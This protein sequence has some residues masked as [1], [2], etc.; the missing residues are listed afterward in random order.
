MDL[1]RRKIAN[2][3]CRL[4]ISL[5]S[6][7]LTSLAVTVRLR[8]RAAPVLADFLQVLIVYVMDPPITNSVQGAFVV[9]AVIT[10][11]IFGALSLIFPEVTEGLA[12]LL[13]GFCLSMWL[14]VLK[15]GGL[16]NSSGTKGIFIGAFCA[17]VYASSFSHYTRPYGLIAST[18][19]AGATVTVLGVD[20][21]SRAGYKE[22]WL[23]IWGMVFFNLSGH[24]H[25]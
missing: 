10:G 21:F 14:L 24:T 23:Y 12:C 11:V 15:P 13:G 6:A 4:H 25:A 2:I 7:F 22:F 19:F 20:C 17:A 9:A 16:L 8:S 5:S 3:L 1:V 18:A